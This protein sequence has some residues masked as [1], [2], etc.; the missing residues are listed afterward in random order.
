MIEPWVSPWSRFVY[1]RLHHEPFEPEAPSWELP[2]SGPLSGANDA[3]PW[4]IFVRDR[5]RFEQEFPQWRIELIQPMMPF[6]YLLSGGVSMRSF[7]PGWSFGLWHSL[8]KALGVW[9]NQLAMFA[10]IV[11][12]RL[13]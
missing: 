9:N 6:R 11:L 8:E 7:A 12:R 4:I 3:F 2:T 10:Q 5:R 13:H 1:S